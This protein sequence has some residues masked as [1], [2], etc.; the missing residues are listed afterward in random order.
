MM[1]LLPLNRHLVVEPIA[2]QKKES[3]VLVP[4]DFRTEESE[5]SLVSLVRAPDDFGVE[6]YGQKLV[7]PTHM[8]QEINVFG[9]KKHVVLENHVIAIVED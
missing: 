5:Y 2:E 9:E 4:D 7:V 8:I 1:K 3:G 6:V